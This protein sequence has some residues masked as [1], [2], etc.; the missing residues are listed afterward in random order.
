V[1]DAHEPILGRARATA[2]AISTRSASCAAGEA[3]L[4][5]ARGRGRARYDAAR[6]APIASARESLPRTIRHAE[7]DSQLQRIFALVD[8]IPRGRVAT[9]GQIAS[10]AGLARRARLVGRAMRELP[11]GTRLPWHRVIAASG[12]ISER[13]GAGPALQRRRLEREGVEFDARGRVDLERFGW[14]PRW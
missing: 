10:E 13:P 12:R 1:A 11:R 9:Y 5:R 8:C 3:A 14:R 7:R 2:A 6:A 4:L